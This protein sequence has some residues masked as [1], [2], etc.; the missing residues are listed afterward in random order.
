M[1]PQKFLE[2]NV[3]SNCNSTTDTKSCRASRFDGYILS[4]VTDTDYFE[5]PKRY[6]HALITSIGSSAIPNPETN[7]QPSPMLSSWWSHGQSRVT[8]SSSA[9]NVSMSTNSNC[10]QS[11]F[12]TR[13][14]RTV[15]SKHTTLNIQKHKED[16]KEPIQHPILNKHPT[17]TRKLGTST[18]RS[19][20]IN[21]IS[22]NALVFV[23]ASIVLS[24]ITGTTGGPGSVSAL[25]TEDA[26]IESIAARHILEGR[27]NT[28][29]AC[30]YYSSPQQCVPTICACADGSFY[31]L[32][33][34]AMKKGEHGCDPPKDKYPGD[35]CSLKISCCK[36]NTWIGTGDE[37][38]VLT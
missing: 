11:L 9:K 13:H 26:L 37:N 30:R 12:P 28:K 23:A 33:R 22:N 24:T 14:L 10:H 3:R 21:K 38:P 20:F 29:S 7:E 15:Y 36:V 32:N 8:P 18:M 5:D 2:S 16:T 6:H 27:V 31:A 25:P 19:T 34:A 35:Q 1:S 17:K 4:H